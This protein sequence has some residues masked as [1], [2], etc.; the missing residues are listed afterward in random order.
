MCTVTTSNNMKMKYCWTY[1]LDTNPSN[2]REIY[3]NKANG[4]INVARADDIMG[5]FAMILGR[6][7]ANQIGGPPFDYT[8]II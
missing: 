8:A 2:C 6:V 1:D 3:P 7:P 5:T 4:Y